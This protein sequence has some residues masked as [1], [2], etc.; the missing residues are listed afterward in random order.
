[1]SN[2]LEAVLMLFLGMILNNYSVIYLN[3]SNIGSLATRCHRQ[4]EFGMTYWYSLHLDFFGLIIQGF[5][6]QSPREESS[7]RPRGSS[8]VPRGR[9]FRGFGRS[10]GGFFG[11]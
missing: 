2:L 1:M 6:F 8:F 10:R 3:A 7:S 5:L 11:R 9:G 4:L